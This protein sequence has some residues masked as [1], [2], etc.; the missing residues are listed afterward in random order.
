MAEPRGPAQS[1][2]ANRARPPYS[3]ADLL[4]RQQAIAKASLS[5]LAPAP[6][7]QGSEGLANPAKNQDGLA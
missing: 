3:S 1:A 6:R 7:N 4:A 2:A 5:G